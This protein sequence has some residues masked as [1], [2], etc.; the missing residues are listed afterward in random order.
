MLT[1]DHNVR[2]ELLA[3]GLDVRDYRERGVALHGLTSFIGLEHDVLRIDVLAVPVR[4]GDRILLC[5]DGVYRQLD[6]DR[7][8]ALLGARRPGSPPKR[9]CARPTSS[10]GATTRPRW[11]C[12]SARWRRRTTVTPRRRCGWRPVPGL[13]CRHPAALLFLSAPD[14][15]L[16]E[17]FTTSA[18]GAELQAV[19]SATV[20]AGF[21]VV[22]YVGVAWHDGVRVMAFGD[23]A[24]ETDQPS[25]PMLSGAGSRTWVEHG[26]WPTPTAPSSRWPAARVDDVT[27]LGAGT[28]AAGGFRLELGGP[29]DSRAATPVTPCR[30]RRQVAARRPCEARR[31]RPS[32]APSRAPAR[33]AGAKTRAA[34][35]AAIQA[36]AVAPRRRS[37]RRPPTPCC[38]RA[39]PHGH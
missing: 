8:R 9:S 13:L 4:T 39:A 23:I 17:A 25:L 21:D 22:P 33:A 3:A 7:L 35:L 19:A 14:R 20:A 6:E 37:G 29:G 32:P 36:T 5:T 12:R 34:A 30:R 11:W 1:H 15:A 27:D 26:V 16:V 31:P 38:A 24:V 28:V 10:V 18:R 2:A